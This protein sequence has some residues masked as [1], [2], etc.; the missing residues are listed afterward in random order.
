MRPY[1]VGEEGPEIVIPERAGTVIPAAQTRQALASP[2][3]LGALMRGAA[4]G[5][6]TI[7][8]SRHVSMPVYTNHSAD[9]ITQSA[10]IAWSLLG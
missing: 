6:T 9:A 3:Q 10:A 8:N 2:N 1:L 7:D 4:G 5:S